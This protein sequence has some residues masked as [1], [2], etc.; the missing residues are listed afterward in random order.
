[1]L[2]VSSSRY[3]RTLERSLKVSLPAL[4]SLIITVNYL[5]RK[6]LK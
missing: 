4:I 5:K 2:W 1:M 6:L 3:T